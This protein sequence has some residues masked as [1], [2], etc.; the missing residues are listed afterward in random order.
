MANKLANI[1]GSGYPGQAANYISGTATDGLTATGSTQG[2]ALLL[3][4]DVNVVTTTAAS[5]GVIL[6]PNSSPG[7]ETVVKNFGAS[8]L[9][10]YPAAGESIDAIAAN[11]AY[12][13]ATTKSVKLYK[14]SATR[15][16][17]LLSA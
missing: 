8:T 5:T 17:S 4:N 7:D 14:S 13:L 9:S 16:I 3:A 10:I 6:A 15:W 2:T 1:I 11:G 12:S